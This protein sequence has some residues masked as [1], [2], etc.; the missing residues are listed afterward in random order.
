[1]IGQ[2]LGGPT[3]QALDPG[4]Q[5]AAG[6]VLARPDPDPGALRAIHWELAPF[7][8]RHCQR[9]YCQDHWTTTVIM[10]D[11]FYDSTDGICPAGHRQM[12]DD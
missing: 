7:W 3:W 2:W 6:E 4:R 9:S 10:D 11:G 12:L 8:C 5:A 1:V